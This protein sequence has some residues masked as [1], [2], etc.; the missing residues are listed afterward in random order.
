MEVESKH[1]HKVET[2]SAA[3]GS[4]GDSKA[5]VETKSSTAASSEPSCLHAQWKHR[6]EFAERDATRTIQSHGDLCDGRW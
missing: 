5:A 1:Q 4:R 2:K 3:S 6:Y